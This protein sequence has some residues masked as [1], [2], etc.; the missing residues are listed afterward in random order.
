MHPFLSN[1][2]PFTHAAAVCVLAL[3]CAATFAQSASAAQPTTPAALVAQ[4]SPFEFHNAFLM[5]LHHFLHK[6]SVLDA[7]LEKLEWIKQP[8]ADELETLKSAVHYYQRQYAG[9]D[10]LFDDELSGLIPALAIADEVHHASGLQLP[11]DLVDQLEAIA[12]IYEKCLWPS[13]QAHNAAWLAKIRP[14]E[15]KYGA[16]IRTAIAHDMQHAF[17]SQP[18]RV[19]LVDD[20][21]SFTG[22]YTLDTGNTIMPATRNGYQDYAAL[23]MLYH[24]AVHVNVDD[25]VEQAVQAAATAQHKEE[26][27]NFTH[28]IHFYTVGVVVKAA[29][30]HGEHIQYQPY[31]YEQGVY[32]RAWPRHLPLIETQWQSYLDGKTAMSTAITEMIKQLPNHAK[33]K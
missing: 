23:E 27:F 26:P 20:T 2:R 30:D 4:G 25:T 6:A 24:E 31:A 13:H 14:L 29:L 22:A 32:R 17:P 28:A 33:G 5:N 10:L 9:K 3:S 1:A 11:A 19:D 7:N 21:G 16:G 18:I 15:A 8:S 12:P